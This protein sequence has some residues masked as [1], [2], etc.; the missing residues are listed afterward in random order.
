MSTEQGTVD[1]TRRVPYLQVPMSIGE[2]V[3]R[4]G[5]M[6]IKLERLQDPQ[7]RLRVQQEYD[8]LSSA[9]DNLDLAVVTAEIRELERVNRALWD[10]E[11][12]IREQ[13]RIRCFDEH[14]IELARQ[15]YLHNDQRAALKQRINCKYGSE[16][17]EEKIYSSSLRAEPLITGHPGNG[18]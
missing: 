8:L 3:D 18:T 11:D 1:E 12:A 15:V 7:K 14:F 16:L 10:I 4:L 2:A 6:S 9:L 13:E 17:M 5:I